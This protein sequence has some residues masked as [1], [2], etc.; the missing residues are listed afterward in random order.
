MSRLDDQSGRYRERRE[1]RKSPDYQEVVVDTRSSR[2]GPD[3]DVIKS[4]RQPSSSVV[5][6]E[7]GYVFSS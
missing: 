7:N 6:E 4:E 5:Q 3:G 1:G 2:A